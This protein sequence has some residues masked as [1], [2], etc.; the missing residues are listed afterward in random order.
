M[1]ISD[2]LNIQMRKFVSPT[3]CRDVN[4]KCFNGGTCINFEGNPRCECPAETYGKFCDI[5]KKRY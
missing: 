4:F 5:G 3:A 2:Q 1:N